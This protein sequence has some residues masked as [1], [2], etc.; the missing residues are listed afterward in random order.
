MKFTDFEGG[1]RVTAF[2]SGGLIPADR[3][4]A[5]ETGLIHIADWF[6][7]FCHMAGIDHHDPSAGP[8]TFPD[9]DGV[10]QTLTVLQGAKSPRQDIP[11]IISSDAIIQWPHKLV[12]GSQKGMGVWTGKKSPN[13]TLVK[14]SDSGC[15]NLG[16][17]FDIEADPTEHNDLQQHHKAPLD[18]TAKL[19][20]TLSLSKK[21]FYQST[22][23]P[24]KGTTGYEKCQSLKAW[25]RAHHNF[26]GPICYADDAFNMK[27]AV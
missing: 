6:V 3:R 15:G 8:Q 2:A 12:L 17:L 1:V 24:V 5:V 23:D 7:T 21:S 10:D 18:L 27:A 25:A 13:S 20:K 14:D 22:V 16:C 4:G 26:A 11:L 9:V 19:S